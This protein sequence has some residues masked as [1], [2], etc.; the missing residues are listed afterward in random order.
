MWI[1]NGNPIMG[2]D[3]AVV[4]NQ[5]KPINMV[6][7]AKISGFLAKNHTKSR[8]NILRLCAARWI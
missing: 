3:W 8:L 2:Y 6:N 4:K 5:P 1:I 7:M